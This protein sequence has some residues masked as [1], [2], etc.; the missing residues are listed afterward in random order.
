M[1]DKEKWIFFFFR[2]KETRETWQL[3]MTHDPEFSFP[4]KDIIEITIK[5]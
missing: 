3:N 4:I 2:L 1:K 5:I